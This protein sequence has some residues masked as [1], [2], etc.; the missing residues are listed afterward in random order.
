MSKA[1]FLGFSFVTPSFTNFMGIVREVFIFGD[2]Y[3]KAK[4]STPTIIDCGANIGTT[5][6]FF[7]WLYPNAKI[8]AF[9]PSP[10]AIS[11]LRKNIELNKFKDI[12]VIEAA[13]SDSEE[14]I[15]F[16]EQPKKSGGSTAVRDVFRSKSSSTEFEEVTVHAV[17]LSKHVHENIDLLKMDI[18]G[19]EG[20][21]IRELSKAGALS[22]IQN[23]I[24]EFHENESNK[25]NDLSEM[26]SLLKSNGFKIVI[27]ASEITPTSERMSRMP[28]H[29]FL[30]RASRPSAVEL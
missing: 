6:V 18:E 10:T 4:S 3:F 11:A 23:I 15:S 24:M 7:K 13:A 26:I 1:R 16:W 12:T 20:I 5:T 14:K 28:A 27:F 8:T 30:L 17:L 25:N 21:V 29:H 9:E 2:Y 19:A 22:K